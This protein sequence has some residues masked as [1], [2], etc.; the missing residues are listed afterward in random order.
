MFKRGKEK[1]EATQ[2]RSGGGEDQKKSGVF[3]LERG[4]GGIRSRR[5]EIEG[6]NRIGAER[7]LVA[8][9]SDLD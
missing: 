1:C 3:A 9:E 7:L 4:R 6:K 8:L 5:R 2:T